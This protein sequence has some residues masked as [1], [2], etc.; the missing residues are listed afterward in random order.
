MIILA[1]GS[2]RRK[3]LLKLIFPEYEV[4][5]SDADEVA[6]PMRPSA[7]VIANAKAKAATVAA[8]PSDIVIAADTLVYMDKMYYLKPTSVKNAHDMLTELSGR[9]HT[10]YSG[11]CILAGGKAHTFCTTSK[12][13]FKRLTSEEI[14]AYIATGSPM[15]KAGAYGIQ[16][17]NI[18]KSYSGSYYNIMGLPVEE[19]KRRLAALSLI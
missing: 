6:Y 12:V 11:V 9:T 19:L 18:V 10:V 7:T 15:D 14:D 1:S 3:E 8:T 13:K 5:V 17:S 2:P 4:R 16:D